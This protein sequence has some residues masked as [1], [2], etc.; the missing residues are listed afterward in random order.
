MN[1]LQT[2]MIVIRKELRDSI[3]DRRTMMAAI[4]F[5]IIGPVLIAG[6]ITV[7]ADRETSNQSY[8]VQ[9]EG[10]EHAQDLMA[11]LKRNQVE[12]DEADDAEVSLIIPDDYA[13]RFE[14]GQVI[15]LVVAADRSKST[16]RRNAR[17]LESTIGAYA[18]QLGQLR[19]MLRGVSGSVARPIE[20]D[21]RDLATPKARASLVLGVLVFYFLLAAFIGSMAVSIDLSA[22][23]RERNSLEVL[24]AQPVSPFVVFTGKTAV[25]SL[26]GGAAIALT[27]IA[28]KLAFIKVPLS[29]IGLT[30][31]MSWSNAGEMIVYLLPLAAMVAALQITLAMWAKTYKEASTYLNMLSF[32]PMML[33]LVV[34]IKEIEPEPWMYAVPLLGHQ[35][36]LRT[37]IRGEPVDL[38]LIG[39]LAVTTLAMAGLLIYAGGRM[40]TRE[41]IIFGQTD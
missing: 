14:N 4:I 18:A 7:T 24:M 3:R 11:F 20:V 17:R 39:L 15:R 30:W 10:T 36:M 13:E 23:E 31:T 41:R 29:K 2:V 38:A 25:A 9:V 40:L 6:M 33:A 8:K 5:A 22:G 27:F 28:S 35:Q 16:T 1:S 34:L 37:M 32:V 12:T 19:L 21:S 26:F